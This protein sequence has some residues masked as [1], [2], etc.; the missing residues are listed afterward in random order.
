MRLFADACFLFAASS[1]FDK[2]VMSMDGWKGAMGDQVM[3]EGSETE[4]GSL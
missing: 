1:G 3:E 4:D 2:V